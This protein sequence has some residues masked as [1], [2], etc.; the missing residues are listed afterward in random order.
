MSSSPILR[1]LSTSTSTSADNREDLINAYEAEEERIINVLS[2]KLEQLREEKISLENTLEAE[3]EF[4]VNRLNRELSLLRVRQRGADDADVSQQQQHGLLDPR[5]PSAETLLEAM[6]KEN[7]SLRN[8]LVDTERDYVR[9]A[10][11]NE[12]YREELIEHRRRLGLSVDTL[13]GLSGSASEPFSQPMHRRSS[14]HSPSHSFTYSTRSA[15]P[16]PRNNTTLHRANATQTPN[17]NSSMDTPLT[18]SPSSSPSPFPFS[19]LTQINPAS[20]ISNATHLTTPSSASLHSAPPPPFPAP[21]PL[22]L[23]YP[24]VPPPSLSSSLGSQFTSMSQSPTDTRSPRSGRAGVRVAE[25]G[26]L[27]DLS[28]SRSRRGST[29]EQRSL[30]PSPALN[31]TSLPAIPIVV[32]PSR[33][34]INNE[35]IARPSSSHRVAETGVLRRNGTATGDHTGGVADT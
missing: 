23:S 7:E 21:A 22:S 16:I 17:D 20:Y 5:F 13:V 4:H 30:P 28:R 3:S 27:R 35:P 12:I 34:G 24:S 10:R 11:L 8:R 15:L 29:T 6:R 2:R 31:G 14:S 25:V 26:N 19:P 32:N 1:R 9:I 33:N 18:N